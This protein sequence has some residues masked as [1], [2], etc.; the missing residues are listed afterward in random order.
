VTTEARVD[1]HHHLWDLAVREQ[2]WTEA[3]PLLHRSF[4]MDDLLPYLVANN[5]TGTVL[6]QTINDPEETP[7]FLV[8]ALESTYVLGVVGW[9]DLTGDAASQIA[10]LRLLPGG[11]FLKGIRHLVQGEPDVNWLARHDVRE[12]LRAVGRANLVYDILVYPHQLDAAISTVRA[13]PEVRFVLD[14]FGKPRIADGDINE[15]RRQM[16]QLAESENVAVKLSGLVTEADHAHWSERDLSPYVQ[17][18]L[19]AFSPQRVMFGSDWPVCQLAATYDEVVNVAE[20][21][22]ALLRHDDKVAIFGATATAWYG[23]EIG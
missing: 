8:Q 4:S 5:I 2:T 22:T 3:L 16:V 13:L 20:S 17:V 21:M 7:E 23:L 18:V 19:D 6:V 14:H 9:I 15:W 11:H 10:H 12:G 1:A